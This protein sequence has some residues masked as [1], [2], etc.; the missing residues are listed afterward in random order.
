MFKF[1]VGISEDGGSAVAKKIAVSFG[2]C[3]YTAIG[4]AKN[5]GQTFIN[6]IQKKYLKKYK[7]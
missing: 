1:G 7:L 3:N 6:V 5:V 2:R 4:K